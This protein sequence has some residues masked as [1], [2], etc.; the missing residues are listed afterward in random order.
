MTIVTVTDRFDHPVEKVW[1]VISNFDIGALMGMA[2][3]LVGDGGMGT[4]RRIDTGAGVI[5]E[6][7]TW[8][9]EATHTFSYTITEGDTLPFERYVSSVRL[10]PDGNATDIEWIGRFEPTIAEE[11]AAK[12]ARNVYAGMIGAVKKALG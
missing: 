4:D 1:P 11:K 10:T 8:L 9:D 7:L 5:V 6:R 3:E 12:V 2:V